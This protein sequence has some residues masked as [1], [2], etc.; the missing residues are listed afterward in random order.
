MSV[1]EHLMENVARVSRNWWLFLLLG[2]LMVVAGV[3]AIV[4]PF[5]SGVAITALV[6]VLFLIE[7]V[8]HFVHTIRAGKGVG[9]L[10]LGIIVA[11]LYA[12]AGLLLLAFPLKGL[13]TLTIVLGA[14]FIGTG[15]LRTIVALEMSG[16]PGWGWMLVGGLLSL[17]L[18]IL[19]YAGLPT[20]IVWAVG[21]IV[22]IDLI[23]FGW[24]L[25][26]EA[27]TAHT[28]GQAGVRLVGQH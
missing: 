19:I 25:I 21:V 2:V 23:F 17:A 1:P 11:V 9:N 15:L 10:I 14:L 3:I 24:A 18:G 6:G 28:I 12:V 13:I 20:S 4:T 7:A 27:I 26:A 5:V 22:G 16:A 8:V